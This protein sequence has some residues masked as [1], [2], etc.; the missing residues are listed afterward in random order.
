[1]RGGELADR[2]CSCVGSLAFEVSAL[3]AGQ[4]L[5]VKIGR[6]TQPGID[7][8]TVGERIGQQARR[9]QHVAK[10]LRARVAR[11]IAGIG[12]PRLGPHR[13]PP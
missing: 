11:G 6:K 5:V 7:R 4:R 9:Q 2:E 10:A 3:A 1:M 8:G 13:N 12:P